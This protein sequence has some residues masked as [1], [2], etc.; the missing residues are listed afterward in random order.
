MSPSV[1]T[2]EWSYGNGKVDKEQHN[3]HFSWWIAIQL[4]KW[5]FGGE[6]G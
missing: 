2:N 3:T 6:N 1:K 5:Q 4:D